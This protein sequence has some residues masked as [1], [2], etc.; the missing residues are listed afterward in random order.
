VIARFERF[1]LSLG[2]A[3][4]LHFMPAE[5][6]LR[7][8][9]RLLGNL[10]P[11]RQTFHSNEVARTSEFLIESMTAVLSAAGLDGSDQLGRFR[12]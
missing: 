5:V 11:L 7:G 10:D 8:A 12:R 9:E 1:R 4:S 6:D 2:F 3:E